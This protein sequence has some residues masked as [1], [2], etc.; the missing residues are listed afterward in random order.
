ME[1]LSYISTNMVRER[2]QTKHKFMKMF[3]LLTVKH[4]PLRRTYL[5]KLYPLTVEIF[6]SVS[7]LYF[8]GRFR[9][10]FVLVCKR[11]S[12]CVLGAVERG[13]HHRS[14]ETVTVIEVFRNSLPNLPNPDEW[15]TVYNK[16]LKLRSKCSEDS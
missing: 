6:H 10:N 15:F 1:V 8:Y 7:L 14:T 13:R 5:L 9:W 3:I 11:E 4:F 2:K 16:Y 12:D